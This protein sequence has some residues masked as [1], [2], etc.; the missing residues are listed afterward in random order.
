MKEYALILWS[1]FM[2]LDQV[3]KVSKV[4]FQIRTK[5]LIKKRRRLNLKKKM[6]SSFKS[7]LK[8]SSF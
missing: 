3:C 5:L 2:S 8:L 4:G 1:L 7:E 6:R